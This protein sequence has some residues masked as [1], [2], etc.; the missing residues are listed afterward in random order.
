MKMKKWYESKTV[1]S[2]LLMVFL[3]ISEMFGLNFPKELY[4]ILAG[5]GLYGI[6]EAIGFKK[7]E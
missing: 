6:R 5:L 3:A 4:S 7:K 1:W 2:A